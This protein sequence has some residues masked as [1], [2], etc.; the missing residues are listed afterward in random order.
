MTGLDTRTTGQ[1]I[2]DSEAAIAASRNPSPR[3]RAAAKIFHDH[4]L[5][6]RRLHG[7]YKKSYEELEAMDPMGFG[8]FNDLVGRALDAADAARAIPK[9]EPLQNPMER[10]DWKGM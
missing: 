7:E 10:K 9:E 2:A 8:E 5:H 3:I 4:D 6:A 1:K